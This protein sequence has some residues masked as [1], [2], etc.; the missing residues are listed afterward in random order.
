MEED[1]SRAGRP[2]R[3]TA[4]AV[5]PSAVPGEYR[6]SPRTRRRCRAAPRRPAPAAAARCPRSVNPGWAIR[7]SRCGWRLSQPPAATRL[8]FA[9]SRADSAAGLRAYDGRGRAF[10][11]PAVA[12]QPE[13]RTAD[14]HRGGRGERRPARADGG[15]SGRWGVAWS[16]Q[17]SNSAERSRSRV[18]GA[19]AVA[20]SAASPSTASRPR[21]HR[22][23]HPPLPPVAGSRSRRAQYER[24]SG[25]PRRE[26][27]ASGPGRVRR[28]RRTAGTA[29]APTRAAAPAAVGRAVGQAIRRSGRPASRA[30]RRTRPRR[31]I[32]VPGA[33]PGPAAS[34]GTP[35]RPRGRRE[36]C[37]SACAVSTRR[38]R[39]SDGGR[40]R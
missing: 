29:E 38:L 26:R 34:P 24:G 9:G 18:S 17:G 2:H 32:A 20:A 36:R 33:V 21:P 7:R 40:T 28:H 12:R 31:T 3:R 37:T 6:V 23:E 4:V 8:T 13:Q 10:R 15:A 30:W 22:T 16:E 11:T 39:P 19:L 5:N 25:R 1:H 27:T 35:S 14:H